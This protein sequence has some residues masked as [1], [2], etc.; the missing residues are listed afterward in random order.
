MIT[1]KISKDSVVMRSMFD[2][3]NS[4]ESYL[5]K[6]SKKSRLTKRDTSIILVTNDYRISKVNEYFTT[7]KISY[8]QSY[9]SIKTLFVSRSAIT[10]KKR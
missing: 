3:I 10:F 5:G 8:K 9:S 4:T 1:R 6:L 7:S 2:S